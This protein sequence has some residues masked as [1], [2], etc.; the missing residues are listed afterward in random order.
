MKAISSLQRSTFRIARSVL[1]VLGRVEMATVIVSL[2]VI[3]ILT[4]V[5]IFLRYGFNESLLWSEEVSLLLMKV[6]VFLG[7]AAIYKM[8]AFIC[9]GFVFN[10]VPTSVQNLFSVLT[11]IAAMVFSL[12]V[13]V[14]G[15]NLYPTQI[16]VRTYLLEL[17]K[18]YF[19]VPLIYGAASIFLTSTYFAAYAA[20]RSLFPE[21]EEFA[22]NI[23][24][25][26]VLPKLGE[27]T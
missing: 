23:E 24:S 20:M 11:S 19:T 22:G 3:C 9:V 18:F 14:Q 8:Q 27:H 1:R 16:S 26:V 5:Q 17:P 2:I 4:G 7:A 25:H 21:D 12:V 10:A 13:V 6:M 15:L